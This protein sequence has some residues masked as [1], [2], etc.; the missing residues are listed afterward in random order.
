MPAPISTALGLTDAGTIGAAGI[1]AGAVGAVTSAIGSYYAAQEQKTALQL[2]ATTAKQQQQ[3]AGVQATND[4]AT[5]QTNSDTTLALAHLNDNLTTATTDMNV[6]VA[7]VTNDF[8]QQLYSANEAI[9][10]GQGDM[11]A[12]IHTGNAQLDEVYAQQELMKGGQQEQQSDLKYALIKSTQRSTLAASGVVLD[13]GSALHMQADTDYESSV[14]AATIHT[15]AAN[16][17]LGYRIQEGNEETAATFSK[18]NASAQALTIQGQALNAN[19]QSET[20]ISNMKLTSS[21]Q[22]LQNDANATITSNND[23]NAGRTAAFNDELKGSTFAAQAGQ[24]EVAADSIS[25]FTIGASTL[26]TGA[27]N[28]DQKWYA[29]S[30]AGAFTGG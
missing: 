15:N 3:L 2:A 27:A 13:E 17:A 11:E 26:L 5:A 8:N 10:K 16:A 4:L 22:I 7:G 19:I 18:L 28:V 25:P 12:A 23:L 6:Q 14:D 1:V 30:Q 24:D 21:F 9:A 29:L 20:D